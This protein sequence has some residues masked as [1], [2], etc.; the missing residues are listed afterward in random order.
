MYGVS[1]QPGQMNRKNKYIDPRRMQAGA[2]T[3]HLKD[4]PPGAVQPINKLHPWMEQQGTEASPEAIEADLYAEQLSAHASNMTEKLAKDDVARLATDRNQEDQYYAEMY[5]VGDEAKSDALPPGLQP[6]A[7][8]RAGALKMKEAENKKMES[9]IRETQ[10]R[11][12]P[13]VKDTMEKIQQAPRQDGIN[14]AP[15]PRLYHK[16]Q[17]LYERSG[18]DSTKRRVSTSGTSMGAPPVVESMTAD[19]KAEAAFSS[20][21]DV[22]NQPDETMVN[23]AMADV[24][25]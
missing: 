13:E 12:M 14:Y 5:G 20:E 21:F 7:T 6:V 11:S 4:P 1:S 10:D 17:G 22:K 24:R 16:E 18:G 9:E 2:K 15:P 19:Q 25:R 8:S 3:S 23:A